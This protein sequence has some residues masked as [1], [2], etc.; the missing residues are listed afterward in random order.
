LDKTHRFRACAKD[1]VETVNEAGGYTLAKSFD[2]RLGLIMFLLVT[3]FIGFGL[4]IPVMPVLVQETGAAPYHLGWLLAIYAFCSFI[5]SPVWGGLSERYGR[6]PLIMIGTI[7]YAVSFFLFGIAADHLWLM[8]VSRILGGCFS[9]AATSVAMAYVADITSEAD[10]NKGMGLAGMSIGLGFIIGPAVGGLLSLVTLTFPFFVASGL[11]LLV[12]AIVYTSL[13][14]TLS[15][16]ERQQQRQQSK[17]SRWTAFT[18]ALKYL[19]IVA[20]IGSFG[21]AGLEAILQYFQ[22]VK[23]QATPFQ[24]GMILLIS[25]IVGALIQGG[26]VRRIPSGSE[27]RF[28][29]IGLV[30]SAVG[31]LLILFSSNFWTATLYVVIFGAGNTLIRPLVTSLVTKKSSVGHGI[32]TGLVTSMDN[33]GRMIGPLAATSMYTANIH[34]PFLVMAAV[35]LL[36]LFLVLGYVHHDKK[37]A[38]SVSKG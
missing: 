4:I 25:G 29:G 17:A 31:M 24:I 6:R 1:A 8:Y 28:I 15:P 35:T 20:F 32:S 5:L 14:E 23:I 38:P 11:A 2:R 36:S 37:M 3:I 21:L 34:L 30:I 19:Y 13:S 10:R 16:E 7:G 12:T 9:G 26:V 33:L 18:G 27:L 22:M